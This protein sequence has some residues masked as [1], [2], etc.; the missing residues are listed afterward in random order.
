MKCTLCHPLCTSGSSAA[1]SL[2]CHPQTCAAAAAPRAAAK[3]RIVLPCIHCSHLSIASK[4]LV[5]A[6][7]SMACLTHLES[8]EAGALLHA[9]S[10]FMLVGQ[11]HG[12]CSVGDVVRDR[13]AEVGPE[14]GEPL[15][16][17]PC[18]SSLIKPSAAEKHASSGRFVK[19][20]AACHG[21]PHLQAAAIHNKPTAAY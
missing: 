20:R 16:S 8:P 13:K 14:N 5:C 3:S 17:A 10:A 19:R 18:L 21:L 4:S 6:P 11:Q 15:S 7:S 12:N 2:K 9:C 1:C